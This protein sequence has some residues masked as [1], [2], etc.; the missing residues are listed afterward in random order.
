VRMVLAAVTMMVAACGDGGSG[1]AAAGQVA[2]TV[3]ALA[4]GTTGTVHEVEM[5]RTSNGDYVFRPAELTVKVG[6]R[7]RWVNVSGGPHNVAFYAERIP[8]GAKA[9][10]NAGMVNRMGALT[11]QLLIQPKAVYEI[12]FD[13]APV[14]TYHYFCTPHEM[15]GMKARLTVIQ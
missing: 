3:P 2:G 12:S 9:F 11:G 8:E 14:G 6:D 7:V 13:G 15:L 5:L 1:S 4:A 10:L